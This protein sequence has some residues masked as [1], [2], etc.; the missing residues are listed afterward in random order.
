VK[1]VDFA[2][3]HQKIL[4]HFVI[5]MYQST[6]NATKTKEK[7]MTINITSHLWRAEGGRRQR[8]AAAESQ[9]RSACCDSF[10]SLASKNLP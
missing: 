7:L 5:I 2:L 3:F 6:I 9:K 1:T 4:D 10:M 8:D